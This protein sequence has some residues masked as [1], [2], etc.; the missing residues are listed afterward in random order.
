MIILELVD[1]EETNTIQEDDDEEEEDDEVEIEELINMKTP[2]D[3][4]SDYCS[5]FQDEDNND[6]KLKEYLK[7]YQIQS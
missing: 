6:T 7:N 2:Y 4:D 5:D 3:D 1:A